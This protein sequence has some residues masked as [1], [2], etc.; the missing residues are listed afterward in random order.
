MARKVLDSIS[1]SLIID[2]LMLTIKPSIGIAVYPSNGNTGQELVANAD[3]AM[4]RA[5]K[6]KTG[7]VF[8]D[9]VKESSDAAVD[10]YGSI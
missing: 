2:D 5:K 7:C 1:Q 9:D 6:T 3:A 4:Y 10:I 8:F